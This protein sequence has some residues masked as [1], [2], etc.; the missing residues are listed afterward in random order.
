MSQAEST[1]SASSVSPIVVSPTPSDEEF[2]AIFAALELA[3]P[4]PVLVAAAPA[5]KS[6]GS[7]KWSGRWWS[8]NRR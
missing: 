1:P 3:W 6:G 7:W 2:A 8:Q 4:R 5:P